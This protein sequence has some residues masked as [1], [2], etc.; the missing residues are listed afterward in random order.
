MNYLEML[1][2]VIPGFNQ[3]WY[4]Y[5]KYDEESFHYN[6][7]MNQK[8]IDGEFD[9]IQIISDQSDNVDNWYNEL[10]FKCQDVFYKVSYTEGSHGYN[11]KIHWDTLKEV[12]SV[13]KEV[14]YY[15]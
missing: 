14:I 13:V 15:E 6:H 12:K 1:Q 10:V 3:K 2:D 7:S 4:E 8:F 5:W 9:K 11:S